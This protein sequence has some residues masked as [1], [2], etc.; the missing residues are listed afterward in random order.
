ME[1]QTGDRV[2]IEV[3]IPKGLTWNSLGSGQRS[4]RLEVT[5]PANTR[6]QAYTGDGNV[7]VTGLKGEV[8]VETGDGNMIGNGLSGRLEAKSGDGNIRVA[9][10][11]DAVEVITGDGNVELDASAGSTAGGAWR[12]RTGDGNIRLKLPSDLKADVDAT[13]GDGRVSSD[14]PMVVGAGKIGGH[15]LRGKLN[16]GGPTVTVRTG[17]GNIHLASA[18]R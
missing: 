7:V 5:V 11:F 14:L 8:R 1:G 4:I 6:L 18:G 17:D 12:V 15:Q 16:G 9:G 10:R 3:R 13:S 2:G